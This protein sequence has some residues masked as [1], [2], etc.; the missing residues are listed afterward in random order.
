MSERVAALEAEKKQL[1]KALEDATH[2]IKVISFPLLK[3]SEFLL[4]Q[5]I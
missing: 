4:K 1:Q 2:P 3:A 5:E